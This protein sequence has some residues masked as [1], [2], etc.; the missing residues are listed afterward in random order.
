MS[1]LPKCP[2]CAS[3]E[4]KNYCDDHRNPSLGHQFRETVD[5]HRAILMPLGIIFVVFSL[6]AFISITFGAILPEKCSK[7]AAAFGDSFGGVNALFSAF[8]FGGLIYTI[9]LQRKELSLQRLELSLTR[10][11]LAKSATSQEVLTKVSMVTSVLDSV[12]AEIAAKETLKTGIMSDPRKTTQGKSAEILKIDEKISTLEK[13]RKYYNDML[14]QFGKE[15]EVV[16][17][18]DIY[19]KDGKLQS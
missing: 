1:E 18:Y 10:D 16:L 6:F 14:I 8:A 12:N 13:R 9:L 15:V 5:T 17:R 19:D 3:S 2:E 4:K 11:E 7:S